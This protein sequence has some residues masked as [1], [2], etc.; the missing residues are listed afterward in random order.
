[1]VGEAFVTALTA[2]TK[3]MPYS[4]RYLARE[5]LSAVRVRPSNAAV[6]LPPANAYVSLPIFIHVFSTPETFEIV[7]KT[8]DI[9]SRKNLAQI[10][11]ILTQITHGREF[12]EDT[13]S[14]IPINGYVSK[15]IGQMTSWLLE[16]SWSDRLILFMTDAFHS[17]QRRRRRIYIPCPRP[18]QEL[19]EALMRPVN[20]VD[21]QRWEEVLDHEMENE[22]V[23]NIDRRMPSTSGADGTYRLEDIRSLKFAAVKALTISFLLDL[24]TL[25]KI[26]RNDGF[27]GILNA[28]AVDVR[29]KHRKRLQ[30]QQEMENMNQALQ[31][32]ERLG[33]PFHEAVVASS[34][35]PAV[36]QAPQFGSYLYTAK[37]LY[38]KAI[39]LSV[40]QYSPRQFDKIHLIISSNTP[41]VFNLLLESTIHGITSRLAGEDIR[42]EDLLQA[43]FDNRSSYSLFNGIVKVNL[44]QFLYQLNKK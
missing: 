27:Q 34:Q 9:G 26:T 17:C 13:P 1:M 44:N 40:D 8:I 20:E 24:E 12:T 37:D 32:Q 31:T 6:L 14:Y 4:M 18:A 2:S 41:G 10:S 19:V 7:G 22:Q 43:R 29:S 21:E 39:L 11:K 30:R 3:K 36:R 16:G 23:R 25:G 42:L 5:T 38:E 33:C 15:A 28:I 35:S